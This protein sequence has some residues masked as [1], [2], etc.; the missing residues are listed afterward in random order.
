MKDKSNNLGFIY[1]VFVGRWSEASLLSH[2]GSV[3]E[4][5]SSLNYDKLLEV[6]VDTIYL[7][8][9]WDNRGPLIV[10][11]EN[12]RDLR[13][14]DDRLP[15][16]FAI[17][18]HKNPNP[19]FGSG[20]DLMQLVEKL[21]QRGFRV[22]ADFV[23]N[24]TST[25]HPWVSS[26]PEYYHQIENSQ[27]AEFSGDVYKLDYGNPSLVEEM[28]KVLEKISGFGFDGV[29]C[30]M[31]HLVPVSFWK[32]AIA[33]L[34]N[35]KPEFAFVGEV[36]PE[37]LFDLKVFSDYFEAGFD[38]LYHEPFF[39]N[40][41]LVFEQGKSLD[42]V[43]G[44]VKYVLDQD[45]VGRMVNFFQNHDD[46]FPT[47]ASVYFETVL[48]LTA[49]L[50]GTMFAYNGS[51]NRHFG[52]LAHHFYQ[53]LVF[54]ESELVRIDDN[55]RKTLEFR[56]SH[57]PMLV[58]LENRDNVIICEI[59]TNEG[60]AVGILN[61]SDKSQALEGFV[62]NKKEGLIR[63]LGVGDSLAPGHGEIFILND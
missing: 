31:A 18:D 39:R 52:R 37:S 4:K 57:S 34:K 27:V 43:L 29:R 8:G 42:Y 15:S 11:E 23:P 22:I 51:L 16:P 25:V 56:K 10:G 7:L 28:V 40:L 21:H 62:A 6:G 32:E 3:F 53:E 36:Y 2:P 13:G 35:D 33:R 5:L 49:F 20:E 30:D 12:G 38:S 45:N 19:L 61:F 9:L 50:P 54:D 63:G 58:D 41:K 24:H 14:R 17:V 59:K 46:D 55:V 1:Q 48:M 26:N 60:K 47:Q 44:H